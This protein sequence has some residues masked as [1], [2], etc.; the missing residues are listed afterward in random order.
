MAETIGDEL[1]ERLASVHAMWTPSGG[2]FLKR[3]VRG[4][5][6]AKGAGT[7]NVTTNNKRGNRQPHLPS[8]QIITS[9]RSG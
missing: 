4:A 9:H 5:Q 3:M 2:N 6:N 1:I 7:T 8:T